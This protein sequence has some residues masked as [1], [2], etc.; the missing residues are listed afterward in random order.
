MSTSRCLSCFTLYTFRFRRRFPTGDQSGTRPWYIRVEPGL[1]A[2]FDAGKNAAF[3]DLTTFEA[4]P[5]VAAT[6]A[7]EFGISRRHPRAADEATVLTGLST[8]R[9]ECFD[10]HLARTAAQQSVGDAPPATEHPCRA[11]HFQ[12]WLA[13][14]SRRGRYYREI[15]RPSWGNADIPHYFAG[16]RGSYGWNRYEFFPLQDSANTGTPLLTSL[17]GDFPATPTRL[18]R[19]VFS[20][21]LYAGKGWGDGTNWGLVPSLSLAYRRTLAF[22]RGTEDQQI[23]APSTTFFTRCHTVDIAAP[24]ELEGF[25]LGAR[26]AA[27]FPRVLFL[28]STALEFRVTHS[29]DVDQWGFR[30]PIYFINDDKGMPNGGILLACTTDGRT[31]VGLELPGSCRASLIISSSFRLL[32]H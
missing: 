22:V 27:R 19:D 18:D 4:T 3:A 15:V 10:D 21:E 20:Y 8:A 6:F 32:G 13:H 26:L 16:L 2:Q 11:E 5:G 1:R 14:R 23:C 31:A 17:P 12:S 25:V 9:R 28:P 29:F 7:L 30:V 24:Y